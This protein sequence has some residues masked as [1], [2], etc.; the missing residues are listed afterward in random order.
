MAEYSW[1]ANE[2]PNNIFLG[3]AKQNALDFGD[4]TGQY[5]GSENGIF[6]EYPV[7]RSTQCQNYDPRFRPWYVQTSTSWPKDI[8]LL[9]D[10]SHSMKDFHRMESAI[11][12]AETI[13]ES[14]GPDDRISV[15]AFSDEIKIL[16]SQNSE[17]HL[18]LNYK[19]E[20]L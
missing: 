3:V 4:I 13:I 12:A 9:I 15:I 7:E 19:V 8:V 17:R 11:H 10:R 18:N 5:F 6:T 1:H 20:S 2:V 16:G 14:L